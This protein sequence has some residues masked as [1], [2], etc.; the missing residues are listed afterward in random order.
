MAILQ[1][2][3]GFVYQVQVVTTF[4]YL[5]EMAREVGE[6]MMNKFTTLFIQSQFSS[7][8]TFNVV[9]VGSSLAFA[10]ST[11]H[12]AMVGQTACVIWSVLSFTC[13]W[14]LLP[15]RPAR[16]TVNEQQFILTAGFAQNWRTAKAIWTHYRKGLKWYLLALI[17]AEASAAAVTSVSVI[18]L[19]NTIG[20]STTQ[21]GIFFIIALVGT[22][23]GAKMGSIITHKTNPNTSWKLSQLSLIIT[24]IIGA[25][26]LE[27]L[28]GSKELSYIWG[29]F[30]GMFLGWF[31]PAEEL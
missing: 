2:I 22:I 3:A 27:N 19:N 14:R 29:F 13:G 24:L 26:T 1:A 12:T 23:P 31:Y 6:R 16:H 8:V 25:F 21:I 17:F 7:E 20:L 4:A 28:K 18:Y 5:P 15:S 10:L 30:V 11:V 9:V